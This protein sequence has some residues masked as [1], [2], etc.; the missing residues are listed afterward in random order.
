MKSKETWAAGAVDF[1][2]GF[3]HPT[4]LL[5]LI[6]AVQLDAREDLERQLKSQREF[7]GRCFVLAVEN[8]IDFR[9]ALFEKYGMC[10]EVKGL[11]EQFSRLHKILTK[12]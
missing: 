7:S 2:L 5:P 6:E 3:V 11:D 12:S 9:N 10:E 4:L 1:N 8:I